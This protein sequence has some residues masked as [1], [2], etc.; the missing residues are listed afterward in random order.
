MFQSQVSAH[1]GPS[2]ALYFAHNLEANASAQFRE[3]CIIH[4]HFYAYI[5]AAMPR[6]A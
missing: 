4:Q 1:P 3:Q 2:L 5:C 6:K